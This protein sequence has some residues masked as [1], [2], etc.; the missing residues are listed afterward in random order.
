MADR[1]LRRAMKAAIVLAALLAL[2]LAPPARA[3]D[4]VLEIEAGTNPDGSMY[5]KPNDVTV[6][7]GDNVTLRIKNVDAIFH[8]VAILGY[9]NEDIENEVPAH[10]TSDR[11][12]HATVAGDF[13]LLCEVTGHKQ[14]GMQGMIHVVSA[15]QA[16]KK[17]PDL[18][19]LG[20]VGVAALLAL[21]RR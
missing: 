4:R 3:A 20:L 1:S 15:A 16:Q 5:L 21:A 19:P 10:T 8:D 7:V 9:D 18:A 17:T 11:T 13:R 6:D 14:K 12:F 2:C